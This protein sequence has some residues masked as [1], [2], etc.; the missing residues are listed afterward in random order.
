MRPRRKTPIPSK[1][2][3]KLSKKEQAELRPWDFGLNLITME[4]ET[5]QIQKPIFYD[6]KLIYDEKHRNRNY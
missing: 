6:Y 4:P 5:R 2:Y 1:P 3:K